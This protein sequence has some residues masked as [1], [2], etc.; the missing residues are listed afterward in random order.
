M[1]CVRRPDISG[2]EQHHEQQVNQNNMSHN[3]L[4]H[5]ST[6]VL[7]RRKPPRQQGSGCGEDTDYLGKPLHGFQCKQTCHHI[8]LSFHIGFSAVPVV[9][10]LAVRSIR[11]RSSGYTGF[12]L[13]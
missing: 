2:G 1:F 5:A 12:D 11:S 9:L 7:T 4:G 10:W 6:W 13:P 8:C 3:Y